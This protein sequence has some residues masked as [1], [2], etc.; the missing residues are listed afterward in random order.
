MDIRS[1]VLGARDG[2]ISPV[3][4]WLDGGGDPDYTDHTGVRLIHIAADS[5]HPAIAKL[6]L[7]RG[8]DPNVVDRNGWT[9]LFRAV[10]ELSLRNDEQRARGLE[11]V[12]LLLAAKADPGSG[13]YLPLA[14][15]AARGNVEAVRALLEGG[16]NIN[17][18]DPRYASTA[19][20]AAVNG[21]HRA[22][23]ELLIAAGANVDQADVRGQT[24]LIRAI[25]GPG[26]VRDSEEC[27]TACLALAQLFVEKGAKVNHAMEDG[28]SPLMCA[29]N[30]NWRPMIRFLL[31]IGADARHVDKRGRGLVRRAVDGILRLSLA[32]GPA[33]ELVRSMVDAG[34]RDFK[35]AANWARKSGRAAL[36]DS[37]EQLAY[38]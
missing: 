23:V 29:V 34:A 5:R 2:R 24:P 11:I 25:F 15:A 16:A 35:D 4:A 38:K 26:T 20:I 7:E 17:Q 21:A 22:I 27:R 30:E 6:L 36:A 28:S 32:D 10:S 31:D 13:A 18:G 33:L 3:Q 1:A 37:I 8:A 14:E 9:P 19:L 12:R